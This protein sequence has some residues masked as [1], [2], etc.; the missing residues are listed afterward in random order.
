MDCGI[1]GKTVNEY[2]R[3]LIHE[4]CEDIKNARFHAKQCVYCGD[5]IG[6]TYYKDTNIKIRSDQHCHDHKYIGYD[7]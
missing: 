7:Q 3:M 1:C 2:N 6:D 5:Y 4:S